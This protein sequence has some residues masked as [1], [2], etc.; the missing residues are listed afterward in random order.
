MPLFNKI[1]IIGLGLIGSSIAKAAKKRGIASHIVAYNKTEATLERAVKMGIIDSAAKSPEDAAKNADLIVLCTPTRTYKQITAKIAKHINE[2]TVLTDAGSVKGEVIE[3]I[4]QSLDKNSA[5]YYVPAH[6]IAGS[7]KSG[8]EAGDADLYEGKKVILTPTGINNAKATDKVKKFWEACGSNVSLM[9]A[10][11]H[12]EIYAL[13][14]HILHFISFAFVNSIKDQPLNNGDSFKKFIRLAGSS[15]AM[16]VDIF[17]HNKKAVLSN[18][19][20]FYSNRAFAKISDKQIQCAIEKRILLGDENMPLHSAGTNVICDILPKLIAFIVINSIKNTEHI[21]GG[22]SG[23]TANILA[24][25][26]DFDFFIKNNTKEVNFAIESFLAEVKKLSALVKDGDA[27]A[28]VEY[29]ARANEVYNNL[30]H[31]SDHE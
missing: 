14:S 8:L 9:K 16:W 15:P 19:N 12:D 29:I 23:I 13:S 17:I 22:F 1:A 4:N 26:G 2:H 21:G 20:K 24:T 11:E 18:L 7:E 3:E 28:I 25:P 27:S 6:P 5:P 30:T 31:A 10:K